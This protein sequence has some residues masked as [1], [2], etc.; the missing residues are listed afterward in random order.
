MN[1]FNRL[2]TVILLQLY[3]WVR[4]VIFWKLN[5][6]DLFQLFFSIGILWYLL[7]SLKCRNMPFERQIALVLH[8]S[9][10][11]RLCN[12]AYNIANVEVL[13]WH[14]KNMKNKT[15]TKEISYKQLPKFQQWSPFIRKYRFRSCVLINRPWFSSQNESYRCVLL[16]GIH[17]AVNFSQFLHL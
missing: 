16:N 1:I 2:V 9:P 13:T 8:K 14:A 7:K 3:W 4:L 15:W 5:L 11:N 17:C 12:Y 10:I 6:K